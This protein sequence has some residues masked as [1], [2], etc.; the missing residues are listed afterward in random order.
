MKVASK[1]RTMTLSPV[2]RKKQMVALRERYSMSLLPEHKILNFIALRSWHFQ[3]R[4]D[5]FIV[6]SAGQVKR[7]SYIDLIMIVDTC[8]LTRQV[9]VGKELG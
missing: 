1:T 7:F 2:T 3:Q 8:A 9:R 5:E 4:E 6:S